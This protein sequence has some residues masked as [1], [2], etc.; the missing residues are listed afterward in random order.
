[1]GVFINTPGGT[2]M[3]RN[4]N[5]PQPLA[6]AA[7]ASAAGEG[8]GPAWPGRLR[9]PARMVALFGGLTGLAAYGPDFGVPAFE[10]YKALL[11]VHIAAALVTFGSTFAIPVLQP[12]AARGGVRTLRLA[13]EFA[14]QL[15]SKVVTPGSFLV[16]ATGVA[17]IFS[18]QTGYS[19]SLP[20]WLIAAMAWALGTGVLAQAVQA[21][22][23][24]KARAILEGV[25][26]GE[27]FPQ[28]LAPI[29]K[30]MRITGQLLAF[31]TLGIMF[32][33]VWKPGV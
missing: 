17:M 7:G 14:E 27:P 6:V 31:S 9:G 21:P 15:E 16:R 32:L 11:F 33:M 10:T 3:L 26:E 24:R 30:R 8:A 12:L 22:N 4:P 25:P 28:E 20:L 1:M 23:A 2:E 19:E 5:Q 29:A 13:L 18:G